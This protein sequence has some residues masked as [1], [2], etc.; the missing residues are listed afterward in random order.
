MLFLPQK[1]GYNGLL[2]ICFVSQRFFLAACVRKEPFRTLET[3]MHHH[4]LMLKPWHP[5]NKNNQRR[6]YEAEQQYKE[7]IKQE[8][9][10]RSE[11]DRNLSMREQQ[12]ML[13]GRE[14]STSAG[15]GS[16]VQGGDKVPA[17]GRDALRFM[18]A[19]PP[20]MSKD[21]QHEQHQG[22]GG[23]M[24]GLGYGANGGQG[25]DDDDEDPVVQEF[26]A[27]FE[28]AQKRKEMKGG[29]NADAEAEADVV[30]TTESGT[31][32]NGLVAAGNSTAHLS[33]TTTSYSI[34]SKNVE[35]SVDEGGHASNGVKK[36][37]TSSRD[38]SSDSDSESSL[39]KRKNS[40][41]RKHR[42]KHKS[43]KKHK[44]KR[45]R[46]D[47]S[48]SDDSSG[49]AGG[50]HG[51]HHTKKHS[52]ND[53]KCEKKNSEKDESEYASVIPTSLTT[54][55]AIMGK[56][57]KREESRNE[58]TKED[59]K[60]LQEEKKK[61]KHKHSSELERMAGR[62]AQNDLTTEDIYERFPWLK[63]APVEA[64]DADNKNVRALLCG[65]V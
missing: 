34:T 60:P 65:R 39:K 40:K 61:I 44:K 13:E 28:A 21:Q 7:R 16:G 15:L 8:Q 33:P 14:T 46:H 12:D 25:L 41:K 27:K 22:S 43:K 57:D 37:R 9:E 53:E 30:A 24:P 56:I 47:S 32:Q 1:K 5:T 17:R 52:S 64:G 59:G 29:A 50:N 23:G 4:Y 6:L 3:M 26:R 49:G 54:G 62:K 20:G 45:K 35:V 63:N 10:A 2:S 31:C 42:S 38:Y 18:Y 19:P 11:L 58:E 55:T 36:S 51:T 48:D